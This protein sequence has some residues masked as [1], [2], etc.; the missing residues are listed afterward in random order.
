MAR[1]PKPSGK[2]HERKAG[3]YDRRAG[4]RPTAMHLLIV[5]EGA[6]TEP[7]Y[8]KALR[9]KLKLRMVEIEIKEDAGAPNTI[10]AT[11]ERIAAKRSKEEKF[12]EIWCVFDREG[13]HY[14]KPFHDAVQKA[15]A[16]HYQLAISNPAFEYWYILHFERT[17]RVFQD[18]KD[19]KDYL[20]KHIP[21]YKENMP[22]FPFL[23]EKTS[24]AISASRQVLE[25]HPCK[26]DL[27]PNPSTFVY[28]LVEELIMMSPSGRAHYLQNKNEFPLED[29]FN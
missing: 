9:K 6:E 13:E 28:E 21:D 23:E 1:T 29:Y 16:L 3:S 2:S 8:F 26:E 11:A 22:V 12:D 18:G 15:Q 7:N 5:C 17:T 24:Y 14:N 4:K 25:T 27:F 10:V 20:Q 19:A